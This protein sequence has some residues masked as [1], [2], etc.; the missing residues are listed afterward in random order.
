MGRVCGWDY[1]IMNGGCR[2]GVLFPTYQLWDAQKATIFLV[3]FSDFIHLAPVV[4]E[5]NDKA[6]HQ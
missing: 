4:M 2:L 1:G 3:F 5:A 6:Q